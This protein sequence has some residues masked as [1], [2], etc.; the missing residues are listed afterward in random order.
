M[1]DRGE[2]PCPC[3]LTVVRQKLADLQDQ[4]RRLERVSHDLESVA[5]MEDALP[6]ETFIE[7]NPYGHVIENLRFQGEATLPR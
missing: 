4:L 7:M 5:D 1:R 3:V 6:D 2:A